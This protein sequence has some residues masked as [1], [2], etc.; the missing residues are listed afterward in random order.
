MTLAKNTQKCAGHVK[1]MSEYQDVFCPLIFPL[2]ERTKQFCTQ[3]TVSL[4]PKWHLMHI[5]GT[6]LRYTVSSNLLKTKSIKFI[7]FKKQETTN[8]R[9]QYVLKLK[10]LNLKWQS[11]SLHSLFIITMNMFRQ[12]QE[13]L[14]HL[15]VISI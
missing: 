13:L 14:F 1:A 8:T 7:R 9:V 10:H 12:H 5:K 2:R 3:I 6:N 4:S 15:F 11:D